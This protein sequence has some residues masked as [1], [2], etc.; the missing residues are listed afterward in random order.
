MLPA[1]V[2]PSDSC[3]FISVQY[4]S[5]SRRG[6]NKKSLTDRNFK[7]EGPHNK[8]IN[9]QT[10]NLAVHSQIPKP[11]HICILVEQTLKTDV[12]MVW[13]HLAVDSLLTV[14]LRN[15]SSI[16]RRGNRSISSPNCQDRLSLTVFLFDGHLVLYPQR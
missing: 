9:K 15:R 12:N 13:V 5:V 16:P 14:K 10:N 4:S 11:K 1:H 6:M 8:N 3:C 7:D 2:F